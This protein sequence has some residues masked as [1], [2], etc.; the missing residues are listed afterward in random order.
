MKLPYVLLA[1][2][3]VSIGSSAQNMQLQWANA[4]SSTGGT[5]SVGQI[6]LD[7]NSNVYVSGGFTGIVDF[8]PGAGVANLTSDSSFG[9]GQSF[10]AKYNS[11]GDYVYVL[12]LGAAIRDIECDKSG[13]VWFTGVFSKIIDMDAGSGVKTLT[14]AG[15]TDFYVAKYD[16]AGAFLNA[17][18][19]GG[20]SIDAS[21]GMTIDPGGNVYLT[22][23]F[24]GTVDFDPGAATANLTSNGSEDIFVARYSSSCNYVN[25]FRLTGTS[26]GLEEGVS[27][28]SDATGVYLGGRIY[29]T[30]D[31][32][33]G[34]GTSTFVSK[35]TDG[36]IAKYDHSGNFIF[37]FNIDGNM[38]SLALDSHS[39]IWAN[40]SMA[41][42]MDADPGP[43]KAMLYAVN[44]KNF[45]V[46]LARYDSGGRYLNART[47]QSDSLII[48]GDNIAVN[49]KGSVFSYG[50]FN[51]VADCN[52]GGSGGQVTTA[53]GYDAYLSKDNAAGAFV[54][55]Y[56]IGNANTDQLYGLAID[57][58]GAIWLAGRF[59]GTL[60]LDPGSGVSNVN[61]TNQGIYVARY[62]D[63]E[64]VTP[65][66]G[67]SE[68][69]NHGL[70]VRIYGSHD[71][72]I[73]DF[74]DLERVNAR[75]TVLNMLGQTVLETE[76]HMND[77]LR[78]HLDAAAS[79]LFV[80]VVRNGSE[81]TM[82][83]ILLR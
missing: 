3:S 15:V 27:L 66:V 31:L 61:S 5:V 29:G 56:G 74:T 48:A 19:V 46:Y 71:A 69:S 23:Y 7:G 10:L 75:V 57:Q 76:H 25:A 1:S 80:V 50:R 2:L 36:F 41:D 64:T 40:G 26:N 34:P 42:S 35:G 16:T 18:S 24:A 53:G 49:Q 51:Q 28:A 8:D 58:N 9:K 52:S 83:K 14:N 12:Q 79:Q 78:L 60:D 47:L 65:G 20:S 21:Y 44:T 43:G 45:D 4:L 54:Q 22:G 82:Q 11:Q 37:G 30:L 68:R 55:A 77:M 59:T 81:Q 62:T 70:P 33:P 32:D 38:Y 13:A 72:V 67:I 63:A 39:N 73:V 6:A 17:F